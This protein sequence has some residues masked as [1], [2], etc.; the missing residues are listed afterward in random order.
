LRSLYKDYIPQTGSGSGLYNAK[1]LLRYL[2]K[3]GFRYDENTTAKDIINFGEML[4]DAN[5]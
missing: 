3:A 2:Y 1:E 4:K 5:E